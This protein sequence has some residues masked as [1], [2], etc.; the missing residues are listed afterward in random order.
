MTAAGFV[1]IE[2][3]LPLAPLFDRFEAALRERGLPVRR[4]P[5]VQVAQGLTEQGREGL[6]ILIASPRGRIDATTMQAL[7]CLHTIVLPTTGIEAVALA[8]ATTHGI[9]VAN[10]GTAENAISLAEATALL[11]LS[12]CYRLPRML[13]GALAAATSIAGDVPEATMLRGRTVG[14]VGY[15][16]I[17]QALAPRL[18]VFEASVLVRSGRH[19]LSA[20]GVQFVALNELLERSDFV[21]VLGALNAATRHLIGRVELGR[22]KRS[23]YLV[24]TA[25][26]ALVDETAL[27]DALRAGELAGAALDVFEREPLPPDSP[28]RALP[29]V[30]LTPHRLGHTR[31]ARASFLPAMIDNVEA[32]RAGRLP[33]RCKNPEV[34]AHWRRLSRAGARPA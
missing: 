28:L 31:E 16:A 10:G 3:D 22:M 30:I 20:P 24:N 11:I 27:A 26:G 33:P 7:A 23:A 1:L 25:R 32:A 19:G 21:C 12:L 13:M 6:E 2:Q 15:G 8:D 5:A 9:A 34:L 14:L 4:G 18:Q 17:A 29:N